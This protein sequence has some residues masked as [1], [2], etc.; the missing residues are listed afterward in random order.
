MNLL[1]K[2]NKVRKRASYNFWVLSI[3]LKFYALKYK[4][5]FETPYK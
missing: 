2:L 5:V 4:H 3:K 1:N